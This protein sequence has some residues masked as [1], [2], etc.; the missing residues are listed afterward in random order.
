MGT[1]MELHHILLAVD[2]FDALSIERS[3]A[4][5]LPPSIQQQGIKAKAAPTAASAEEVVGDKPLADKAAAGTEVNSMFSP[6]WLQ[7][8]LGR[9]P[10]AK[11][12]GV[13]TGVLYLAGQEQ[14]L[15]EDSDMGPEFR[16]RRHF[17]YLT[18]ADFPGCAVTYD[19]QCDYLILWV[20]QT[21]PRT[22]LWYGR[23]PTIEQCKA[24]T[25]VDDVRPIK[26]LSRALCGV[27]RPPGN[28]VYALHPD[29][30]PRF[31]HHKG[32][33]HIDTT[34]LKPAIERA[35]VIKTD[36]EIELIRR[37]NAVSSSA[38]KAV[39]T[40]IKRCKNERDILALFTSHCL[41][42]GAKQQAY[43]VI[44][45]SG[46]NGSTLHYTDNDQPLAGRQLVVLDAGA[47]WR[48]YASDITR[49]FPLRGAFTPQAAAIH[50]IVERMQ[51]ECIERIRPGVSFHAL[52][53]HACVVAVT[54]LLALGV[55][56]HT[57]SVAEIIGRG[58]V[59]AFFPHGLG[60]HVGLE[61]H[62]VSGRQ[63]L[64]ATTSASA[65]AAATVRAT[66]AGARRPPKREWVNPEMLASLYW[67]AVS[68]MKKT[69]TTGAVGDLPPNRVV[70]SSQGGGDGRQKLEKNMVVTVEPGIYFCR[71]YIE[72]F[73]LNDSAHSK[74]INKEELA[75]YWDVGG[76]RIED[77]ILVTE[78]GY[79]NLT[80]A[81]KGEEMLKI[82]NEGSAE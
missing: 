45:A 36:Y 57:S 22:V 78:R 1:E 7:R 73:F 76:V 13:R 21:D 56:H 29:Q 17:Y 79:E 3:P 37:A 12:L 23:T 33:V 43:P 42:H 51:N 62:D 55:L 24:A 10:V 30:V 58:T 48:C 20:P 54:E 61:V 64:L 15:Y 34:K 70:A 41:H 8:D 39:L 74:Y 11:E 32:T 82:I 4:S 2:E 40:Q 19:I 59:A 16:Q 52:H 65:S 71:E 66:V 60:H 68:S 72:S 53:L 67:D 27:F 31:E 28:T 18:G 69:T 9:F 25:H 44:A 81:P 63:R 50:R 6:A 26:D 77:D 49:T 35:R 80:S 14:Q 47:E 75:K 46:A 5:E 38:H